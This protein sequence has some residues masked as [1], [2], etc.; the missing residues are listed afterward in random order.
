MK[1][2]SLLLLALA[3]IMAIYA[4]TFVKVTDPAT[5][6]DGDQVLMAYEEGNKASDS[7][8]SNK[9]YIAATNATFTDDQLTITEPNTIT[10]KQVGSYWNLYINNKP[11]GHKSGNSDLDASQKTTTN[12]AISIDNGNAKIISQTPGKNSNEVFF[13]YNA[14]SSRFALYHASSN[15]KAINLYP[16]G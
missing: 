16:P 10:I 6:K 5:L 2:L 9:K 13:A 4:E 1:R 11:V 12:F 7:F 3:S 15:M 8:H 14:S